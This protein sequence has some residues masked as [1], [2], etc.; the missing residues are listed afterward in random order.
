MPAG[1]TGIAQLRFQLDQFEARVIGQ[2]AQIQLVIFL[3][4]RL[5]EI[6]LCHVGV[7]L[8]TIILV[9]KI[10]TVPTFVNN[11]LRPIFII[12]PCATYY[13]VFVILDLF[14]FYVIAVLILRGRTRAL[15][16][17]GA[18]LISVFRVLQFIF[19]QFDQGRLDRSLCL[20]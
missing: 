7:H 16:L 9:L 17:C 3:E 13:G 19:N 4:L 15:G 12:D 1:Q 11:S 2:L 18:F 10:L 14:I 8:F 6:V 20:I 5:V